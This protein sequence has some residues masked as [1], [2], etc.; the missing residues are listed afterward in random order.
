MIDLALWLHPLDGEN[1]SGEEL[2]N[3][4]RFH[5][6]E[7]LAEPQIKVIHDERNRPSSQQSIPVDWSA[8]LA[9]AEELRRD[10]RDLR[11]LVIVTRGL[12]NESGFAGLVDGLTLIAQTLDLHWETL[13]PAL[14]SGVPTREAALRRVNA[15]RDLQLDGRNGRGGL[16]ADLRQMTVLAPR[17]VGPVL[18]RDLEQ[19]ALDERTMLQEAPQGLNSTEKASLSAAHE[20]LLVRLRTGFLAQIDQAREPL[21]GLATDVEA[22]LSA[23]G[24]IDS[25]L[26]RRLGDGG[27]GDGATFLPELKRYLE[28]VQTT[29]QRGVGAKDGVRNPPKAEASDGDP[30]LAPHPANGHDNATEP[31]RGASNGTSL[32]DRIWSRD[33][34]VRCL[35]LV[36]AFY[37]RT[38][39]SSPIPHLARRIRRMVPMDFIELMEDL[40]PSGLKEFRLLTGAADAKKTAQKDER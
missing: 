26:N 11:L 25:V 4:S 9:K 27:D 33:D 13:H 37:D 3:D 40:A 20:Q 29:V 39:P 38:E 21:D 24:T 28:R 22:A 10:G 2:R 18:G 32:P 6:L 14:R 30:V 16:L 23:L 36:V 7:R 35:D 17:G 1:P 15:L 12:A 34:V 5:E 19:G 8:V 31:E